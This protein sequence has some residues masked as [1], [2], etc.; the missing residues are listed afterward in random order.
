VNTARCVQLAAAF[1][2]T[3][4]L[5]GTFAAHG[6]EGRIAPRDLQIWETGARYHMYH[7]LALL[8]T[9]WAIHLL[10]SKAFTVGAWLFAVGIVLFAGS[11]YLLAT[12]TVLFGAR[13]GWLGAITPLGGSCFLAGWLCLFIGAFRSSKASAHGK[14]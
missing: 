10:P 11:L 1:G 9:A 6:L 12:S 13:W 4:V 8:G 7:A 3:A 2:L 5:A 14:L